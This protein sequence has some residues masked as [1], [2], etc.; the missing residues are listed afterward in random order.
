MA[1]T[2]QRYI[3]C[4]DRTCGTVDR[5]YNCIVPED[6]K[7]IVLQDIQHLVSSMYILYISNLGVVFIPFRSFLGQR[8]SL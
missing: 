5:R 8:V 7:L 4:L 6:T 1:A 3:Y 2:L